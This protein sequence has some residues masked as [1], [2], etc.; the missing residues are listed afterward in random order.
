MRCERNEVAVRFSDPHS[1]GH[2]NYAIYLHYLEVA[3]NQ[4]WMKIVSV[5]HS[6]LD[7]R[8]PGLVSVRTEVDYRVPAE[9][10][11]NLEVE[12]WVSAMEIL[13]YNPVPNRR[14]N[15]QKLVVRQRRFRL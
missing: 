3:L 10:N 7:S 13:S 12:I 1:L 8:N 9:Y 11:Q 5:P 15:S 6:S 2:V 14:K 4:F